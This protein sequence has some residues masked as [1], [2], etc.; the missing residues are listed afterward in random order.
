MHYNRAR[1]CSIAHLLDFNGMLRA[2]RLGPITT[3][4]R[5][6]Q[7]ELRTIITVYYRTTM[8]C[9]RGKIRR[10]SNP[11]AKTKTLVYRLPSGPFDGLT[12]R[13]EFRS[14]S[15]RASKYIRLSVSHPPGPNGKGMVGEAVPI[16]CL[17]RG[18]EKF[19]TTSVLC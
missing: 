7:A 16:R 6:P 19:Q 3:N 8:R 9:S 10:D 11:S 4:T 2:F 5:F 13:T 12:M 1:N 18:D 15:G 17:R 14:V